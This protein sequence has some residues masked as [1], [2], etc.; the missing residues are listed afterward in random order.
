[1][2]ILRS[3][4]SFVGQSTNDPAKNS[5]FFRARNIAGSCDLSSIIHELDQEKFLEPFSLLVE[6]KYSAEIIKTGFKA[7]KN[8]WE[9]FAALWLYDVPTAEHSIRTMALAKRIATDQMEGPRGEK[10]T[11]EKLVENKLPLEQFLRA[12][13]FHDIGKIALPREVVNNAL[14]DKE[15]GELFMDTLRGKDRNAILETAGLDPNNI[16]SSE[17]ALRLLYTRGLRPKDVVPVSVIFAGPQSDT[18]RAIERKGF[19]TEE[20]LGEIMS[21]HEQEGEKIFARIDPDVADIIGH[22][23]PGVRLPQQKDL[24]TAKEAETG[25]RRYAIHF[26]L[27]VVDEYDAIGHQR[28]YKKALKKAETLS[29]L[30]HETVS[31]RLEKGITYLWLKERYKT[32]KREPGD[33]KFCKTIEDFLENIENKNAVNELVKIIV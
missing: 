14:G 30:A 12:A 13:L 20:T 5:D 4:F 33:E 18:L 23:H 9:F 31:G 29:I 1:M 21:R 27:A 22:H 19:S 2:G 10:I 7:T 16:K 8:D 25:L 11:L 6:K 3:L 26:M 15:M 32:L 17:D 28:N 24:N